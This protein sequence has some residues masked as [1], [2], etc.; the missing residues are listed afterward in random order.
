MS[1]ILYQF[2]VNKKC[3]L[4]LL[5]KNT[6]KKVIN[7]L[8]KVVEIKL[9]DSEVYNEYSVI[10][11]YKNGSDIIVCE[12]RKEAKKYEL[13]PIYLL[14]YAPIRFVLE[15]VRGDLLRGVTH[16]IVDY[17]TTDGNLNFAFDVSTSQIIS[18]III[19]VTLLY[20]LYRYLLA[21]QVK[22]ALADDCDLSFYVEDEETDDTLTSEENA[23][24]AETEELVEESEEQNTEGEKEE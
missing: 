1:I 6:V 3:V 13:L 9:E 23:E 7:N 15:M 18:L 4:S 16:V 22:A 21:K 24:N 12:N 11:L 20:L 14:L 10:V 8:S 2:S 17:N 19:A 5:Q